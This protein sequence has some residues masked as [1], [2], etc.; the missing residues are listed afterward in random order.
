MRHIYYIYRSVA[1]S[2][3]RAGSGRCI[4]GDPHEYPWS[5]RL[6]FAAEREIRARRSLKNPF[7]G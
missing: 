7:A 5:R 2:A 6:D 4:S 3:N 1:P